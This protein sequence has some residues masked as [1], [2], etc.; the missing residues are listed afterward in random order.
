[1]SEEILTKLASV[2][3]AGY[4]LAYGHLWDRFPTMAQLALYRREDGAFFCAIQGCEVAGPPVRGE[5]MMVTIG[6]IVLCHDH[7]EAARKVMR[8][9]LDARDSADDKVCKWHYLSKTLHFSELSDK[10]HAQRAEKDGEENRHAK[11]A[12]QEIAGRGEHLRKALEWGPRHAKWVASQRAEQVI[13]QEREARARAP[14]TAGAITARAD[15]EVVSES[16]PDPN[17]PFLGKTQEELDAAR[18]TVL[19]AQNKLREFASQGALDKDTATAQGAQFARALRQ[20]NE[21]EAALKR[22]AEA[23]EAEAEAALRCKAKAV[24]D[25]DWAKLGIGDKPIRI[26][27][28]ASKPTPRQPA[29]ATSEQSGGSP[30]ITVACNM[31]TAVHGSP[32]E[33]VPDLW[34]HERDFPDHHACDRA[35]TET[36]DP[37]H[38]ILL[39]HAQEGADRDEVL[40]GGPQGSRAAQV[41]KDVQEKAKACLLH[42]PVARALGGYRGAVIR[43]YTANWPQAWDERMRAAKTK[44]KVNGHD[45][46]GGPKCEI[47]GG[48]GGSKQAQVKEA[49]KDE[50]GVDTGESRTVT[51]RV[52]KACKNRLTASRREA[53]LGERRARE[54]EYRKGFKPNDGSGLLNKHFKKGGKDKSTR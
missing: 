25:E 33:G 32:R 39:D 43:H 17:N 41:K 44:G 29:T 1:M 14:E 16:E 6:P 10:Q 45:S 5:D 26:Q 4:F 46:N 47:C 31:N 52:C 50:E 35:L 20:I 22:A 23:A 18:A 11:R 27:T 51:K 24:M 8:E 3:K 9:K 37:W 38:R 15:A 28:L 53:K 2:E 34:F 21:A 36:G 30:G 54:A 42:G 48:P 12:A 13:Q 19:E 40:Y 7:G 49:V